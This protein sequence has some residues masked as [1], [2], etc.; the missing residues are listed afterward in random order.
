M[1]SG[2][3]VWR[4]RSFGALFV[5]LGATVGL[6]A[7]LAMPSDA[8]VDQ[9][10]LTSTISGTVSDW[11]GTPVADAQVDL[12]YRAGDD[13]LER[14][15]FLGFASTDEA[16][17]FSFDVADGCYVL[18]F[19][20]PG[21]REYVSGRYHRVGA[22]AVAGDP[23]PSIDVALSATDVVRTAAIGGMVTNADG[24]PAFPSRVHLYEAGADGSRATWLGSIWTEQGA[25]SFD[26]TP[27]CYILDFAPPE[28]GRFD[29][30]LWYQVGACVEAGEV[31]TD[32]SA[33][34]DPVTTTS[35]GG[36]VQDDAFRAVDG[37]QV[38]LWVECCGQGTRSEFLGSTVTGVDG[39]YLL[40]LDEG[41]C[42]AL[43]FI[44]PDG[45][46][47][48]GSR[49][50]E[51]RTCLETGERVGGIDA[52]PTVDG[53]QSRLSGEV[54]GDY[55]MRLLHNFRVTLWRTEAD[56][57]RGE[58]IESTF[59]DGLEV[60]SYSFQVSAGCYW[61]VFEPPEGRTFFGE[62]FDEVA[63]CVGPFEE[64]TGLDTIIDSTNGVTYAPAT[65]ARTLIPEPVDGEAIANVPVTL[66]RVWDRP[67]SVRWDTN[68]LIPEGR[69]LASPFDYTASAGELLFPP[70]E[71]VQDIGIVVFGD[72][73]EESEE[74]FRIRLLEIR[75]GDLSP[76][77]GSRQTII[78]NGL[79]TPQAVIVGDGSAYEGEAGVDQRWLVDFALLHPPESQFQVQFD[80][81]LR[82]V[83][84]TDDNQD[85]TSYRGSSFLSPGSSQTVIVVRVRGDD[86]VEP[87]EQ[88]EVFVTDVRGLQRSVSVDLSDTGVFTILNDDDVDVAPNGAVSVA[89]GSISVIEEDHT[90][91]FL[92]SVTVDSPSPIQR[93]V[94]LD[95]EA[96]TAT[97]GEDYRADEFHRFHIPAGATEAQHRIYILGDSVAEPD[98]TFTVK[99]IRPSPGLVVAD[100]ISEITIVDND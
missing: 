90:G 24:T 93:S 44:A 51:R 47:F 50:A 17:G 32:V 99:L 63:A 19:I 10:D 12:F 61:L 67:V 58:F 9:V 55:E 83:A 5:V 66:D 54:F 22:C 36:L 45:Y 89:E 13:G 57:S 76:Y 81:E 75:F 35:I 73:R 3:R 11:D 49:Y 71:A 52:R 56:G 79:G 27:G 48:D 85:L 59:T 42:Y 65:V 64:V 14:A 15:D 78:D 87:D 16:G 28:G 60:E 7:L 37:V 74:D 92:F 86:E 41:G 6:V 4:P 68:D 25:Y 33:Q 95:F 62:P 1:G 29:R 82:P 26:V 34:L 53:R 94:W 20:A 21:D 98:E 43:V 91:W 18:V 88:F 96:G 38:D 46:S 23:P 8:A 80:W 30:G 69:E 2:R 84:G 39:R 40:R 100:G 70:G 97:E 72:D 77:G 31:L